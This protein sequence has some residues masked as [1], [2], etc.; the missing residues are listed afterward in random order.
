MQ[1]NQNI[2]IQIAQQ[3]PARDELVSD[4]ISTPVALSVQA[5]EVE[6]KRKSFLSILKDVFSLAFP[7]TVSGLSLTSCLKASKAIANTAVDIIL[8]VASNIC[9]IPDGFREG[10]PYETCVEGALSNAKVASCPT[11]EV[12][13]GVERV[14]DLGLGC[15]NTTGAI[16][17][18]KLACNG[19]VYL[20]SEELKDQQKLCKAALE[21]TNR[22]GTS[23]VREAISN[24]IA[25]N[26]RLAESVKFLSS[27]T[28]G[29]ATANLV[30]NT[31]GLVIECCKE[32]KQKQQ[33]IQNAIAEVNNQIDRNN[34]I[35]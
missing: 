17:A 5:P 14:I 7:A 26:N 16:V 27:I 24:L 4:T 29:L 20:Y 33:N 23:L 32:K 10:G 31:V 28:F 8:P 11:R 2:H 21:E 1:E 25:N 19:G 15:M 22:H 30:Y 6:S 12:I 18:A 34:T 3:Q 13:D 9:D 35:L